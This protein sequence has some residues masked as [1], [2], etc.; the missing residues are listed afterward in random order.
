M[1]KRPRLSRPF[2]VSMLAIAGLLV[3]S[4]FPLSRIRAANVRA[5]ILPSAG[6][7]LVNLK[8]SQNLKLTYTGSADAVA[9][10]QAGAAKPTALAS[11]DFNSDGAIDVVAGYSTKSGGAL[12][13][14]H[15]NS[16]A[17]T[18]TDQTLYGKAILQGKVPP[19]FLAQASA[20]T[21]PESPD[22]LV[23][24]DFNRDGR[25]DVLVA[26]RGSTNLYLLAG[27]GHGNL[28]APQAVPVPGQVRAL[29][30]TADGYIALSMDGP[31]GSEL[32]ILDPSAHSLS[33]RAIYPL[34]AQGNS[35]VWGRLAGG[36]DVAVGAGSSVVLIYGPLAAQPQTETV[37]VPYQVQGLTL[38][39][40][41]W[42]RDGRIEIAVLAGDGSI[43]I[44]Q[45][46][47]LNTTPLT[48]AELPA[49][50][51]AL[52][53]RHAKPAAAPNPTALGP[54]NEARQLP[55]SGSAPSGPVSPSAFSSPRLANSSTHD[56]MVLDAA[57]SQLH[58]LDTSGKTASPSADV[59]FSGTPVAALA[60]PNKINSD[61]DIVVLTS[62]QSAPMLVTSGATLTLNVN[63]TVETD[64]IKACTNPGVTT[65]PS[66]LSL[67]EAVCLANNYAPDTTTINLPAGTYNLESDTGGETGELQQATGLAYSL[68]INGTGTAAN[69]IISQADFQDRILE[70]DYGL[71]GNSP[72]T[73]ENVTLQG[74]QCTFGI[75]CEYGG[76]AVL[77]GGAVGDNLTI[78]NVVM[79]NNYVNYVNV[80]GP[81]PNDGGA[82]N[83]PG[84]AL[85]ISNSTF[86]GNYAD[87]GATSNSGEGGGVFFDDQQLA[88]SSANGPLT[89]TNSS[90]T[91]NTANG[92][93]GGGLYAAVSTGDPLLI[94]G[95]TFTGNAVESNSEDGGGIFADQGG[96]TATT[97]T[98]SNSRIVGNTVPS[99][100]TGTGAY[101]AEATAILANN[102]WGCNAGPGNS[103]CDSVFPNTSSTYTPVLTLSF[104]AS[105]TEIAPNGTSLLTATLSNSDTCTGY[106]GNAC[107]IPD[108]T[109]VTF[110]GTLGS[111]SPT[112][113]T[114]TSG[115]A[116]STYTAS[117]QGA[118]TATATVDNQTLSV[119]IN[120]GTPPA[121]ISGNNTT[122]TVGT[123]GSFSVTIAGAPTPTISDGGA[124]LPSGVTF[125]DN[126]NDTATLSGTPGAGTGGVYAFTITA[127]NGF[128]PNA[129]QNF[130]L[131]VNPVQFQ[132][133]M[134]ANPT[135]GGTVTPAS[136]G[137][138]NSGTVVPITATAASGYAF[139][140]WTSSPDSVANPT[141]AS[142]TITMNAAEGV[143]ANFSALATGV[144]TAT[145]LTSTPN[146][147]FTTAPDNAVTFAATVSS[148]GTVNEGTITFTD[149][150]NILT[151]SGGNTVAVSS[152]QAQCVTSFS[153]EGT[154][155]ITG[156]YN[157]TVNFQPSSGMVSQVVN[158]HTVVIG[159]QF[160]NQGPITV[161]STTGA[162]TPYPSN[163]FVSGFSGNLSAVTVQL[164]DISSSNIQQTDLLLVGPT[165]A[166]IIPFASVGD[167]STISG[168]NITVDD[169]ASGLIP[170]GSLLVS[171]T[172]QPTSKT[173]STTLVFPVPAPTVVA[174]E[175]AA[176]DGAATLTSRFGGTAPNGTWALYAMDNS[177]NGGAT[178]NGGWC[179]NIT[180]ATVSTTITTSPAGLLVSVDGGTF[181]AA[182]LVANWTP[183]SSHTITTE[184]P[185]FGATGVQYV[186][187]SWSDSGAIS[188]SIT[189][190]NTATTYTAGFSPQYQLTTAANPSNGG[191]VMPS[192]GAFYLSGE[193]VPL[194]ATPNAGYTFTNWTG[195]VANQNSPTT[196]ITMTAPQF[197]TANF[198]STPQ[199]SL[200][201]GSINYGTVY[202]DSI[203]DKNIT[204]KNIGTSTVA[205]NSVSL[206]LGSGTNAGD[207]TYMNL[208]PK[209][210]PAGRSCFISTAFF[211]GNIGSLSATLN[212]NDN[213]AGSPQQVSLS[214]TVINPL[215]QLLT[216]Q[217]ELRDGRDRP[218]PHQE[219]NPHQHRHNRVGYHQRQHHGSGQ[220]RLRAEQR[221]SQFACANWQLHH[222]GHV[223]AHHNGT[224]LSRSDDHRQ[225]RNQ[226]AERFAYGKGEP[227]GNG[228]FRVF[229]GNGGV[230]L[231]SKLAGVGR[232][233][234]TPGTV[235]RTAVFKTACFNHSHIPRACGKQ[236]NRFPRCRQKSTP[237]GGIPGF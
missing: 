203:K 161:P 202:L 56:L 141:S 182:P 82:L 131:T 44:L 103:G 122:F 175:Y 23:T 90:F 91:N 26:A 143:T 116:S 127:S 158:N 159:N 227:I 58:I 170:A 100:G 184:T 152:G 149:S 93:S 120:I 43:H 85:T 229:R 38:G 237:Y 165:G 185:Q 106:A 118:G 207:F 7:P 145:S 169:T 92:G 128:L 21:L 210:L 136:G 211:A 224:A 234:R 179:V 86:S 9:A 129:T 166:E 57:A 34:Q 25:Q 50:R 36:L 110:G 186:W 156:A 235:S 11:A 164:N 30:A 54:W 78:T 208:C 236:R 3:L 87:G 55:Y 146:P 187:S 155:V 171:G 193:I 51:A 212:I 104:G 41:I 101:V 221:L 201:P 139:V 98:I 108:G 196:T 148:T 130:T 66:T 176:T 151:C 102:W 63:T 218:Q 45:H 95:S 213:A 190:P 65:I 94:T 109:G 107:Y 48:A 232:G 111:D 1:M 13:L 195:N 132:L 167:G 178:I 157:G 138:Y 74:G 228:I 189:V 35:V 71:I 144:P 37:T 147:S 46:G 60:L 69:T 24:G 33:V 168:V 209:T 125:H 72:V 225:R 67:R 84:P 28:L 220:Q 192:S 126:G 200:T 133:T 15:G 10:L 119:T 62:S 4:Y 140:N 135:G 153:T 199:I 14:F 52:R 73:I 8:T 173:G 150:L 64:S 39:D 217:P 75:D 6:K 216:G 83:F 160:C 47:T 194:T 88:G 137:S 68:T 12:A 76:G 223:H 121:I 40:F 198:T 22:L 206:T 215:S 114:F 214:A 18:P 142:T 99:G 96:I 31:A 61:R 112:S 29:A 123:S 219:R 115:T 188:H 70:A 197:V 49:R 19:T 117:A 124:S 180:P 113:S 230:S 205:I 42:D 2:C 16:D 183:G 181:T 172:Y 32:A 97:V 204:V 231:Q 81:G 5:T 222:L 177:G 105:S 134:A 79:S 233:I 226:Q 174:G 162:A 191:A 59:S 17:F 154:D 27:D 80:Q 89:I 163:I 53:G 20:F 77:A